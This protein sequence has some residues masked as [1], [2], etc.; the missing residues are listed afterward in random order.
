M[1]IGEAFEKSDFSKRAEIDYQCT[2]IATDT[3]E[4]YTLKNYKIYCRND[5]FDRSENC[6]LEIRI[7]SVNESPK[8]S[9]RLDPQNDREQLRNRLKILKF[10]SYLT[11]VFL[12]LFEN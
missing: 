12:D 3:L 7:E 10:F 8:D 1:K 5:L 6:Q 4:L 2:M 11:T 9:F